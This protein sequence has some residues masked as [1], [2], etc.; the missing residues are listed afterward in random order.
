MRRQAKTALLPQQRGASRARLYHPPN[1][2]IFADA[3][4]GL[5]WNPWGDSINLIEDG[6]TNKT[7][8]IYGTT[9]DRKYEIND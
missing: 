4:T 7:Y 2:K 8:R 1:V 9:L 6:P 3:A 5:A